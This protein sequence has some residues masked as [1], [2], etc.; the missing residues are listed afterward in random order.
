MPASIFQTL[1]IMT[2]TGIAAT[3][4][5]DLWAVSISRV[6]G[7]P[8]TNWALVGRWVSHLPRGTF[9]HLPITAT[10][11]VPMERLIGWCAHYLVGVAYAIIY[12]AILGGLHRTPSLGS[13][14]LFGLVTLLAPWIIL[15]PGMGLGLFARSTPNP[16]RMRCMN[17]AAHAIFGLGL[18]GGWCL[19]APVFQ[20]G[21]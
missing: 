11:A 12:L 4:L 19:M 9:R 16:A 3:A 17:V 1:F 20:R 14:I 5:L 2:L 7:W 13:A 18:Y 10:S 21:L 6:L 15:Q 8:P